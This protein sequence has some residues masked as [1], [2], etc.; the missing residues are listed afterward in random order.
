MNSS[1]LSPVSPD[2]SPLPRQNRRI[3]LFIIL[4][5]DG[6]LIDETSR[7]LLPGVSLILDT[8]KKEGHFLSVCSNNIMAKEILLSLH[9]EEKFDHVFGRPSSTYKGL[10]LLLCWN[11]YLERYRKRIIRSK[12]RAKRIVFI[13]NDADTISNVGTLFQGV[14]CFPS[15]NS[16]WCSELFHCC[17][18]PSSAASGSCTRTTVMKGIFDMFG[19]TAMTFPT[20]GDVYLSSRA[21]CLENPGGMSNMKF[22]VTPTCIALRRSRNVYAVTKTAALEEKHGQ[23]HQCWFVSEAN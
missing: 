6:T 5:L 19:P 4:D 14:R 8:L 20:F 17:S 18:E 9:I 11:Y 15:V 22:H 1:P 16:F 23:C 7:V 13:D 3:R 21:R 2:G 10:E 12:I